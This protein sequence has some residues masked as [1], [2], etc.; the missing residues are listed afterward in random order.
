MDKLQPIRLDDVDWETTTG[1]QEDCRTGLVQLNEKVG[2]RHFGVKAGSG[3]LLDN[4]FINVQS[5]T[6]VKKFGHDIATVNVEVENLL[7]LVEEFSTLVVCSKVIFLTF[8]SDDY[9][10]NLIVFH[11]TINELEAFTG[12]ETRKLS[13]LKRFNVGSDETLK[14]ACNFKS[15]EDMV[16]VNS[17]ERLLPCPSCI[18]GKELMVG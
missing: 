11:R 5:N 6:N 12:S 10:G 16:H 9:N 14:P 17:V 8:K 15:L 2:L 7:S 4:V 1:L 3:K 18:L 13:E